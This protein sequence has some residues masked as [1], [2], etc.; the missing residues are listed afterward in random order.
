M[1]KKA[2]RRL[3]LRYL[4]RRF[5]QQRERGQLLNLNR[6]LHLIRKYIRR[7]TGARISE[8]KILSE[9]MQ[10]I[11]RKH[12]VCYPASTNPENKELCVIAKSHVPRL[13]KKAN[14]GQRI[15]H[16]LHWGNLA[17]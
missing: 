10:M 7:E 5:F 12:L 3:R 15:N 16:F 6:D 1:A 17:A 2:I 8:G 13:S 14:R 9:I 11:D 4:I